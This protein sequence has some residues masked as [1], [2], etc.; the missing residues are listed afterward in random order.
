MGSGITADRSAQITGTGRIT[1]GATQS[2]VVASGKRL[3]LAAPIDVTGQT[4]N[5]S[6]AGDVWIMKDPYNGYI[7]PLSCIHGTGTIVKSGNGLLYFQA[8]NEFTG[9]LQV[10]GGQVWV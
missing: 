10:L 7:P 1:I 8:L 2:W 9:D 6:G 5:V 4:I 3:T